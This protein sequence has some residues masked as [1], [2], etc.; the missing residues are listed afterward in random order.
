MGMKVT[1]MKEGGNMVQVTKNGVDY[2]W[3]NKEGATYYGADTNAFPLTRG[4]IL[5]GGIRFAAVTAEH[6]L[7]YDTEWNASFEES[8]DG[9]SKSIVLSIT[10]S[11]E[12]RGALND[13]LSQELFSIGTGPMSKYPVT[14]LTFTYRITLKAGEEFVRLQM[15]VNNDTPRRVNAEAWLPMTFPIDESSQIIS[16]QKF[17]LRKDEWV[18]PTEPNVVKFDAASHRRHILEWPGSGI[19]SQAK[20]LDTWSVNLALT[21]GCPLCLQYYDW[22]SMDGAMI[23]GRSVGYHA[24]S[25]PN[26]GKT[27]GKG[28]AFVTDN[29]VPHFT[30]LWSWGNR[31][32]FTPKPDSTERGDVLAMGRPAKEYYEP[33]SSGFNPGFF[34]SAQFEPFTKSSWT[35]CLVPIDNG[36]DGE[37]YEALCLKVEETIEAL[38]V[39]TSPAI[40]NVPRF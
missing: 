25:L 32:N 10:D 12:Q 1:A 19:V 24:T 31:A 21:L 36:M 38:D 16:P 17:R 33:W 6:G 7:Y 2:V 26:S 37:N 11:A 34:Q 3:D 14:D 39:P 4:L 23:N 18:F 28:V 13:P 40:H 27:K 9:L 30:K 20:A 5:H 35:G 29:S 22:P 8:E 15:S